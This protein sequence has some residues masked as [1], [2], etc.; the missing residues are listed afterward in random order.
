MALAVV[1]RP[2]EEVR[3]GPRLLRIGA[4]PPDEEIREADVLVT[5]GSTAVP[6]G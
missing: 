5:V 2:P 1:D 6:R 3:D 4:L